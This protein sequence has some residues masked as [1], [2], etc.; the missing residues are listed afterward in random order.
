[1]LEETPQEDRP[2]CSAAVHENAAAAA[3]QLEALLRYGRRLEAVLQKT[4]AALGGGSWPDQ[5][6]QIGLEVKS[7]EA[8]W[9]QLGAVRLA[10]ESEPGNAGERPVSTSLQENRDIIATLYQLPIN[11]DVVIRLLQIPASP[12]VKA[13]LVFLDGMVDK[14]I[15]N[16]AVLQP[17]MLMGRQERDLYGGGLVD[18]V[19]ERYL[20][21]GQAGRAGG[22]RE[23]QDAVNSGDAVLFFDGV[24]EAITVETK[25]FEHRSI[26]RPTTEQTVRGSQNA[27]TEVLRVNTALI[28]TMFHS[29]DL[30]TEMMPVGR[31]GRCNCALMYVRSIA[32]PVLVAEVK[33]RIEGIAVD[34]VTDTDLLQQYLVDFPKHPFPQTLSTERPERVAV[35]LAEGRVAILDRKSV[36]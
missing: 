18:A 35:H 36:V 16:L 24:A 7:L 32:N 5:A 29:S 26:D 28:R 23:V 21:S 34:L 14:T 15:I 3:R 30:V 11:K 25:G 2:V 1:M 10:Y 19:L 9:R 8:Q 33:R 12:P 22:F 20:P 13:M 4:L 6:A 27:F 31:R 17:L